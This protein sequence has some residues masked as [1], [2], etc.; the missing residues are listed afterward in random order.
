MTKKF[1]T[2]ALCLCL[3]AGAFAQPYSGG[4]G[5]ASDP[6]LISNKT[7][8]EALATAVNSGTSYANT[9]FRLT[10]DLTEITTVIGNTYDRPYFNGTFD[11]GRA[12]AEC[13]YQYGCGVCRRFRTCRERYD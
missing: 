11:G 7:N 4:T 13:N 6:Y 10:E 8:M 5:V 1:F 9:H 3:A 2:M 12:C